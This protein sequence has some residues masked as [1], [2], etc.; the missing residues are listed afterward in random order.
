MLSSLVKEHHSKQSAHK[1][2]QGL[3][4]KLSS[5][6]PAARILSYLV[7]LLTEQKRKEAI[8]AANNLTQ[9]LVDHLNVGYVE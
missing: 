2:R 4:H 1:E 5:D 6:A 8:G 9:A 7:S 3:F